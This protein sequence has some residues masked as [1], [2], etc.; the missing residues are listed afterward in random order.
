MKGIHFDGYKVKEGQRANKELAHRLEPELRTQLFAIQHLSMQLIYIGKV[1]LD[2][3]VLRE[4][5]AANDWHNRD[6][7]T[8]KWTMK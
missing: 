2:F 3:R 8:I 6:S 4:Y 1:C 7:I 5:V